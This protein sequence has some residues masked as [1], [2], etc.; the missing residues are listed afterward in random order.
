METLSQ[1][2]L[3]RVRISSRVRIPP[4]TVSGM[5]M[6]SDVRRTTSSM[7]SRSSWLAAMS[8]KTSSSAR[9]RLATRRHLNGIAGVAKI[10]KIDP[11]DH[12]PGMHVKA[13]NNPLGEHGPFTVWSGDRR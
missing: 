11:L 4:P 7:I 5:K 6:T 10:E 12:A 3:S 2:A 8:R 9:F 1:P 13:R